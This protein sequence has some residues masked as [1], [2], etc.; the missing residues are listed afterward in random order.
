MTISNYTHH[1]GKYL[2][3]G[4]SPEA[5]LLSLIELKKADETIRNTGF[6]IRFYLKVMGLAD[7]LDFPNL[8]REI[9]LPIVLSRKEIEKMIFE[10]KNMNHRLIIMMAYATGMRVSE[11]INLKW[12]DID[13]QRI[14]IHIK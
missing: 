1:I 12:E 11:L 3:S 5:Y 7:E 13:F 9:K 14:I 10:T 6:A 2:E 8:K 4:K